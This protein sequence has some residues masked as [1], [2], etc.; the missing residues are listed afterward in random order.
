MR[1]DVQP[2][3]ISRVVKNWPRFW[4]LLA[5][6]TVL[7]LSAAFAQA[8]TLKVLY[9]F[10]CL[11]PGGCAPQAGP[12]LDGSGNLYGTTYSGGAG[13]YGVAF[14][15]S[16]IGASWVLNPLYSFNAGEDGGYLGVGSLIRVA[17][18][19]LFGTT[20]AGGSKGG[21]T[22]FSLRP[23]PTVCRVVTCSWT[24][25]VLHPFGGGND[26]ANPDGT[27]VF[28]SAGN[29]YGT[30]LNG[31]A[32]G[33]GTVWELTPSGGSWTET[34]LYNFTGGSDGANPTGV[35]LDSAGNL[36][37]TT[38][39][40]GIDDNGTVFE[41]TRSGS[42]WTKTT[43]YTFQS[44]PG[45]GDPQGVIVDEAGNL[46]GGTARGGAYGSGTVYEL[47][48]SQ[49]GWMFTTLYNF[50]GNDYAGPG[51]ILTRDASGN[52]YGATYGAG[53]YGYGSVFKLT[54]SDGGWNFADLHDFTGGD[55]GGL[56]GGALVL[57]PAGNI[58]GT[59]VEGG[60]YGYGV[61]FEI[62]P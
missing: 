37:G 6:L 29:L 50:N 8:Q 34:I 41:L 19:T 1:Q 47:S 18:G 30:T 61:L 17:D 42:G 38:A 51:N 14:K 16:H 2:M 32:Y 54:R 13:D 52:L 28:D 33:N 23:G 11:G 9:S 12:T 39:S 36:Y 25:T 20:Y 56:P 59:T 48:P 62:T 44:V 35:V 4:P 21:G 40:G 57:D 46:Y 49:G 31:G 43:L 3:K 15:L 60:S 5:L 55:D 26:G 45:G 53:L 24:V 22:A 27:I 10:T 7:G 58:Y